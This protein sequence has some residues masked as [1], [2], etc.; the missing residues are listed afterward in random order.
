MKLI[1]ILSKLQESNS[2]YV[3]L[4]YTGDIMF[5]NNHREDEERFYNKTV[6]TIKLGTTS[7]NKPV[8]EIMLEANI[9]SEEG[10]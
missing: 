3:V 6:D 4:R 7:S 2:R 8:V 1:D 10:C 5:D 9:Y